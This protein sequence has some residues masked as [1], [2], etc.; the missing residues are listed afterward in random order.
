MVLL[1]VA[2][3]VSFAGVLA[4]ACKDWKKKTAAQ[5]TL[6]NMR[7]HFQEYNTH[8]LQ[9]TTSEEAGYQTANNT[10]TPVPNL[11]PVPTNTNPTP[12]ATP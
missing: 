5:Q 4:D 1:L 6:D 7:T 9:A 12:I 2:P 10:T 11:M 3:A 8:C